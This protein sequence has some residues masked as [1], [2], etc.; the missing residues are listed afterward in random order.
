MMLAAAVHL[1]SPYLAN[2]MFPDE[3][4]YLVDL[5][6]YFSFFNQLPV[7]VI[8]FAT[9][10]FSTK[11]QSS[12]ALSRGWLVVAIFGLILIALVRFPGP[13]HIIFGIAFGALTYILGRT[14]SNMLVTRAICRVGKVSFSAYLWHAA[15]LHF[16]NLTLAALGLEHLTGAISF[17]AESAWRSLRHYRFRN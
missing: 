11:Q 6:I 5:F 8:G 14:P 3:P 17:F 12:E 1:A 7:F 4:K 15:V 10:I 16:I 2:A 13:Q 9:Y